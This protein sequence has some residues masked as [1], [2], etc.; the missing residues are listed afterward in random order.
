MAGSRDR[1]MILRRPAPHRVVN[2]PKNES[3]E[4][5]RANGL[6]NPATLVADRVAVT[7][8]IRGLAIMDG[9]TTYAELT[10]SVTSPTPIPRAAVRRAGVLA[11]RTEGEMVRR[12]SMSSTR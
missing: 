12:C 5:A 6:T 8:C 1:F 7:D 3:A 11:A 10:A 9:I 4:K 2:R